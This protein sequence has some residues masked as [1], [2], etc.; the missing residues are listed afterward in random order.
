MAKRIVGL[1]GRGRGPRIF[2]GHEATTLHAEIRGLPAEQTVEVHVEHSEGRSTHL[3]VA[4]GEMEI[5][6]GHCV[7]F[8][9]EGNG[10][11]ICAV[12]VA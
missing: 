10:L 4:N 3:V 2:V 5:S 12:K 8:V 1:V 9:Y 6:M 11:P 7:H